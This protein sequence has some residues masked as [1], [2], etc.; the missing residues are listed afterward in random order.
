MLLPGIETCVR[1]V[2]YKKTVTMSSEFYD[3]PANPTWPN[4]VSGINNG[5]WFGWSCSSTKKQENS[6]PWLLLDLEGSYI[7]SGMKI[8]NRVDCC[9]KYKNKGN[10]FIWNHH[11]LTEN[12][13]AEKS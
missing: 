12:R 13:L 1:D 10:I 3:P 6:Y 8:V 5:Q 9:R 2:A 7:I 11:C 4:A